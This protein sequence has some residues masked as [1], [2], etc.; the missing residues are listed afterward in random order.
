MVIVDLIPDYNNHIYLFIPII[1]IYDCGA[2]IADPAVG[3]VGM[4]RVLTKH[5]V[6]PQRGPVTTTRHQTRH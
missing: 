1:I 6:P 3:G 4:D 2:R 5:A